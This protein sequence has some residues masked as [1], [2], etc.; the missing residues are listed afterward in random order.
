MPWSPY[1]QQQPQQTPQ[2]PQQT[3]PPPGYMGQDPQKSFFKR[4]FEAKQR[5]QQQQQAQPDQQSA[6]RSDDFSPVGSDGRITPGGPPQQQMQAKQQQM[7]QQWDPSRDMAS[8]WAQFQQWQAQQANQG[9]GRD[10]GSS[11]SNFQAPPGGPSTLDMYQRYNATPINQPNADIPD[12]VRAE[13]G[14][15]IGAMTATQS[16]QVNQTRNEG[17]TMLGGPLNLQGWK[18]PEDYGEVT[19]EQ[20]MAGKEHWRKL[21]EQRTGNPNFWKDLQNGT[22]ILDNPGLVWVQGPGGTW[23]TMSTQDWEKQNRGGMPS[24]VPEAALYRAGNLGNQAFSTY[25]PA[26]FR[27]NMPGQ[28]QKT[29]FSQFAGPN[30]QRLDDQQ[31]QMFEQI[32]AN[33]ETMNANVVSAMKNQLRETQA[34]QLAAANQAG[35]Q[36]FASMGRLGGGMQQT[37]EASA[38]DMAAKNLLAGNRDIMLAKAERDRADQL[39]AAQGATAFQDAQMGRF[40]SAYDR[41]LAGE[42][43]QAGENQYGQEDLWKRSIMDQDVQR[44]NA[45]ERFKGYQSRFS[46]EGAALERALEQQ[47][48]NQAQANI[49]GGLWGQSRGFDAQEKARQTQ[50]MLGLKNIGVQ[51]GQ[52]GIDRERLAMQDR[53]FGETMGFNKLQLGTGAQLDWGKLIANMGLN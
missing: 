46:A 8:Q 41:A 11:W 29:Q 49:A 45:G 23:G 43:A 20:K 13:Q 38:R 18:G 33:P 3:A 27:A 35:Q 42:S 6:P 34:N 47:K 5:L 48:L 26:T 50:E 22:P 16:Q 53:H 7:T 1:S 52:L 25:D 44:A 39:A 24:D 37:A 17:N 30:Q 9:G 21:M 28:Y 14:S 31:R 19:D 40:T 36:R 32:L 2:A 12:W 51:E 15:N 10:G 4:Q